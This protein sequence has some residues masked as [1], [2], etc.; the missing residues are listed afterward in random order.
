MDPQNAITAPTLT[1]VNA[2]STDNVLSPTRSC[3]QS[4]LKAHTCRH[5]ERCCFTPQRSH[6]SM[7]RAVGIATQDATGIPIS[8]SECASDEVDSASKDSEN[9]SKSQLLVFAS[10]TMQDGKHRQ[11]EVQKPSLPSKKTVRF[12]QEVC[13]LCDEHDLCECVVQLC[14]DPHSPTSD[15][16]LSPPEPQTLPQPQSSSEQQPLQVH[17][18]TQQSQSQQELSTQPPLIE[19]ASRS[20]TKDV[21]TINSHNK[22]FT[23]RSCSRDKESFELKGRARRLTGCFSALDKVPSCADNGEADDANVQCHESEPANVSSGSSKP[24]L[25]ASTINSGGMPVSSSSIKSYERGRLW[26][27]GDSSLSTSQT[28]VDTSTAISK[29]ASI[30]CAVSE[31]CPSAQHSSLSTQTDTQKRPSSHQ[32]SVEIRGESE[33][34]NTRR[35]KRGYEWL[36]GFSSA[37]DSVGD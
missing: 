23:S 31:I 11:S 18:L 9:S 10:N 15:V 24:H 17:Q 22:S 27:A 3:S 1:N 34:C 28:C 20:L 12:D 7:T 2:L 13:V 14:V 30:S 21:H 5:G 4:Q 26:L 19:Q 32:L 33:G 36:R 6:R 8:F 25:P 35:Y 29:E 37:S 16:E